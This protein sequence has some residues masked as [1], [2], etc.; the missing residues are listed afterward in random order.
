[1]FK[2]TMIAA[3]ALASMAVPSIAHAGKISQKIHLLSDLRDAKK[4]MVLQL[5]VDWKTGD[6]HLTREEYRAKL[7]QLQ[8]SLDKLAGKIETLK[9]KRASA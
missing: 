3:A 5:K 4:Q 2:N 1:M 6:S 7:A 9:D 8:A